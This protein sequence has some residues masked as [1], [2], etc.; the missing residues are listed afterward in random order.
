MSDLESTLFQWRDGA[1]RVR[2]SLPDERLAMDRVVDRIVAEL[3]RRL[4][5]AFT[6]DELVALYDQGTQWCSDI[7]YA[8]APGAPWAW[9]ARLTADAAFDRYV[10]EASDYAGGRRLDSFP[11]DR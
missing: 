4:G 8:V 7:A 6:I 10:H 1:R 2:E 11:A 9:D 3:R 5:G